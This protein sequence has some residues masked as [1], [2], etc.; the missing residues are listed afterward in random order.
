[1]QS[2]GYNFQFNY[3]LPVD[4]HTVLVEATAFS[5]A[6]IDFNILSDTVNEWIRKREIPGTIGRVERGII[7]MGIRTKPDDNFGTPIGTRGEMGRDSSGYTFFTVQKWVKAAA[8]SLIYENKILP[9]SKS[10][11]EI[12]SDN[13][14]L[15]IIEKN[16]SVLPTLFM[17]IAR[18]ISPDHF[19]EFMTA[20]S[21]KNLTQIIR[22]AP[23][24][25]FL[26]AVFF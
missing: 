9:Y 2:K 26:N 19:A 4:Q 1:M 5:N 24:K 12:E 17:T 18:N 14:F 7:P 21:I 25:P 13:I 15:K 10:I 16:P 11:L 3:L 8:K 23:K 6:P 22:C 20:V